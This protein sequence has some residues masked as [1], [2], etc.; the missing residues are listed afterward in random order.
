MQRNER[1]WEK[2]I[3]SDWSKC[4]QK[5]NYMVCLQGV[6]E[7]RIKIPDHNFLQTN[8]VGVFIENTHWTENGAHFLRC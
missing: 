7:F 1:N 2:N 6:N 3:K 5:I 8:F 4:N